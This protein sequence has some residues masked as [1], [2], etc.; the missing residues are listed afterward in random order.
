[1]VADL[2]W[3]WTPSPPRVPVYGNV[4]VGGAAGRPGVR[5]TPGH[6]LG[7][8]GAPRLLGPAGGVGRGQWHFRRAA[9]EAPCVAVWRGSASA[10]APRLTAL[11][12]SPSAAQG[13]RFLGEPFSTNR[14]RER[15][16]AAARGPRY[17]ASNARPA[18]PVRTVRTPP[19]T[20]LQLGVGG[21]GLKAQRARRVQAESLLLHPRA[22]PKARPC[23][24][25]PPVRD[26]RLSRLSP[27]PQSPTS[28]WATST[29][30]GS[31]SRTISASLHSKKKTI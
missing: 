28:P 27:E 26:Q 5:R 3:T 31:P 16:L 24:R 18:R 19:A 21:S 10:P 4:A 22:L 12:L 9:F 23:T 7:V 14:S 13:R 1:M 2:T 8:L 29:R 11:W 30:S 6:A 17:T 25:A 20:R 15:Q